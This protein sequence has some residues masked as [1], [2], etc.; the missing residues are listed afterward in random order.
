[1]R[2]DYESKNKKE[3]KKTFFTIIFAVIATISAYAQEPVKIDFNYKK[4]FKVGTMWLDSNQ[5]GKPEADELYFF[6]DRCNLILDYKYFKS[7]GSLLSIIMA[8]ESEGE[9]NIFKINLEDVSLLN[10]KTSKSDDYFILNKLNEA[11]VGLT[12]S[13]SSYTFIIMNPAVVEMK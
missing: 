12:K 1:M 11:P 13:D 2:N 9:N 6:G 7:A 3:M 5:N 8:I 10:K 4:M